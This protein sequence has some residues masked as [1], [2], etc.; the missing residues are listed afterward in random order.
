MPRVLHLDDA[1]GMCMACTGTLIEHSV[2]HLEAGRDLVRCVQ[3]T[4]RT[5]ARPSGPGV[6]HWWTKYVWDTAARRSRQV[7][8][9]RRI[10]RACTI[11]LLAA[12]FWPS[13]APQPWL[14]AKPISLDGQLAS[15]IA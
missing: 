12:S 10:V 15:A 4:P 1:L 9:A 5:S 3:L 2:L 11:A 6:S 14:E 13:A 7:R 8:P